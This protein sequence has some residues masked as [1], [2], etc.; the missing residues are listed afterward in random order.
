MCELIK[1]ENNHRTTQAL[2]HGPNTPVL[3]YTTADIIT[4]ILDRIIIFYRL[5]NGQIRYN[6]PT[7]IVHKVHKTPF[8]N[9]HLCSQS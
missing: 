1:H 6:A 9:C 5:S 7:L 4:C 3:S 8:Q 2:K